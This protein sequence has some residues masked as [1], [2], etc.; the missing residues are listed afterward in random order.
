MAENSKA[1][2]FEITELFKKIKTIENVIGLGD[3]DISVITDKLYTLE[4]TLQTISNSYTNRTYVDNRLLEKINKTG[5]TILGNL[6]LLATPTNNKHLVTKEYVDNIIKNIDKLQIDLSDYATKSYV[7][8][9]V[10]NRV[11]IYGDVLMGELILAN[12][13]SNPLH[14]VPKQQLDLAVASVV[15]TGNLD[16]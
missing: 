15:R 16:W 4:Q 9:S 13:A 5:D 7:D 1:F 6:E 14:P 8:I 12:E 3:F 10:S 11:S 2:T